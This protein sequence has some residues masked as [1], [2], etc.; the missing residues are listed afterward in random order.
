[1]PARH[2]R[3]TLAVALI[4]LLAGAGLGA[5]AASASTLYGHD[6]SWPQC[7]TS[8]G[9]SGLPLPPTTTQFVVLGLT[10]GLPFTENPCLASQV[11]WARDN[12]KPTQAYTM[13]AFPTAAQLSAYAAGGPWSSRST[14]GGSCPTSATARHGTPWPRLNRIGYVPAGVDRCRAATRPSRGPSG[15]APRSGKTATSSRAFMRAL[16]DAG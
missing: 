11:Q 16:R 6:V 12:G 1:M 10:H 9:G 13:A 7:P 3:L 4:A 14:R 8:V 15:S 2:R 5:P